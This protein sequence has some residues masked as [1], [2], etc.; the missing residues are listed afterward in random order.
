MQHLHFN[1][2][3]VNSEENT[4]DNEDFC[5]TILQLFQF[6]SE[7]EKNVVM[8]HLFAVNAFLEA[9]VQ[10]YSLKEVYFKISQIWQGN[11]CAL[12]RDSNIG[13]FPWNLRIF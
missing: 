10:R 1:E 6:D 8:K 3:S 9:V 2:K 11:T 12:R 7:E 13:T 5:S 4:S